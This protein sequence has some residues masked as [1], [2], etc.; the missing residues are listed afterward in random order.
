MRPTDAPT[1]KRK[2]MEQLGIGTFVRACTCVAMPV[3]GSRMVPGA[4]A[5]L[6]ASSCLQASSPHVCVSGSVTAM[7]A[8]IASATQAVRDAA[9]AVGDASSDEIA[10]AIDAAMGAVAV[11]VDAAAAIPAT[12]RASTS[13][14]MPVSPRARSWRREVKDLATRTAYA[15][16]QVAL[17]AINALVPP[18]EGRASYAVLVEATHTVRQRTL[19]TRR[20]LAA[21]DCSAD[22]AGAVDTAKVAKREEAGEAGVVDITSEVGKEYGAAALA[23][24]AAQS[25]GRAMSQDVADSSDGG[26]ASSGSVGQAGDDGHVRT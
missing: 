4:A 5:A 21:L 16:T 12:P 18:A 25:T 10:A 8:A 2:R 14:D 22:P 1:R 13:K 20:A 23:A 24:L 3:P 6:A 9:G 15:T 11:L 26:A 7:H 17:E 19:A